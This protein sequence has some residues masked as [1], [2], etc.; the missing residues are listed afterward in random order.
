MALTRAIYAI[1]KQK[2]YNFT[3]NTLKAYLSSQASSLSAFMISKTHI[4]GQKPRGRK[5]NAKVSF[6]V[7]FFLRY[8]FCSNNDNS[9]TVQA[10]TL[11]LAR[12]GCS[13]QRAASQ[14]LSDFI[15]SNL[16]WSK[17]LFSALPGCCPL[18]RMPFSNLVRMHAS[19]LVHKPGHWF[20]NETS[21]HVKSRVDQHGWHGLLGRLMD[22]T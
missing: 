21:A 4:S 6:F 9:K 14:P 7:V 19:S 18:R 5:L 12:N 8:D 22:I 16:L 15:A 17:K 10:L 3:T 11:I 1:L 13:S 20:E 2:P